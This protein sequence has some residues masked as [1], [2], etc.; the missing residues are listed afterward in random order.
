[1]RRMMRSVGR[2]LPRSGPERETLREKG[3]FWTPDWIAEAMV[4]YVTGDGCDTVFDPAVGAGAFFRAA[5]ALAKRK[6]VSLRLAGCEMDPGALVKAREH[7]L[8]EC[9]L[10][11]VEMR[12][13]VL[14]PPPGP[15]RA[16]VANPPYIRHHR[17]SAEAKAQMRGF[18]ARLLGHTIDG[19]AGVHV[20]FLLRAL[21]LLDR[22]GRLSFIMPADTCEGVFAPPLWRWIASRYRLDAVVTFSPEATPF[23]DVDTNAVIFM[24]ENSTPKET[25]HWVR[26]LEPG[27]SRLTGLVE[28]GFLGSEEPAVSVVKRELG[29]A[30]S[31][32]LS[33]QP[34]E[35]PREGRLVLGDF[36]RILR[37]IA[38]GANEFFFLTSERATG[39]AIPSEYLIPAIGRTRDVAGDELTAGTLRELEARGR[40]S[41]LFSVGGRPKEL[42][43]EAV[44]AYLD[45]GERLGLPMRPLIASR[46]PWYKMEVR[47]P[48]PFLF[49][50][51]GRRNARFVRNTACVVPLTGFLCVYPLDKSRHSCEKLWA[52]LRRP[53]TVS[54]LAMVGKSYG[55]GAI[56]VEPRALERLV[57][58]ASVAAS[59]GLEPLPR[60]NQ[61]RLI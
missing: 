31:T 53:E 39:L 24:I 12:D 18:G 17:L 40:P 21:Q 7:G 54:N 26:C 44:R 1:M 8:S 42:L 50:Y 51:L 23:P 28:S 16:V 5:K 61:M 49:A 25:L 4:A 37:G 35:P 30:L 45:H 41:L 29:E 57:L 59:V 60:T 56:K 20:Y 46:N 48:P 13:F 43:P 3:Q 52:A 36:A 11:G 22:G 47:E 9:D 2:P 27:T 32:G 58:P 19:R 38:T 34:S 6:G 33:R 15:F 55:G 10:H 14:H